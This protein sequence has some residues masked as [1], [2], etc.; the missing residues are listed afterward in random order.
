MNNRSTIPPDASPTEGRRPERW[1]RARGR[2]LALASLV[3][4]ILLATLWSVASVSG[5]GFF[6]GEKV[7]EASA[8]TPG[9]D[10]QEIGQDQPAGGGSQENGATQDSPPQ[11]G[12]SDAAG[13]NEEAYA[14]FGDE[15][16]PFKPVLSQASEAGAGTGE[17]GTEGGNGGGAD[18]DANTDGT[19]ADANTDVG[20]NA[21]ASTGGSTNGG[22][23]GGGNGGTD[24]GGGNRPSGQG[25]ED[26]VMDPNGEM[27]DCSDTGSDFERI[28]CEEDRQAGD[29]GSGDTTQA[30]QD[31]RGQQGPPGSGGSGRSG[32]GDTA[33]DFR[34]GG[35]GVSK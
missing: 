16:N 10:Q 26:M 9:E 27:V 25:G 35:G 11:T 30:P 2:R 8:Q 23:G 33:D 28:I 1:Q 21:D 12:D 15:R 19:N 3:S 34:N 14:A 20:P 29:T 5:A 6:G 18:A 22:T 7:R 13:Y 17:D 4:V 24:G 31:G 32:A